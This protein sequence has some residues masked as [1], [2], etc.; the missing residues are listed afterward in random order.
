MVHCRYFVLSW[1]TPLFLCLVPFFSAR[2]VLGEKKL[3]FHPC[4]EVS[5][6]LPPLLYVAIKHPR[7]F[8]NGDP[9][10]HHHGFGYFMASCVRELSPLFQLFNQSVEG[11][12]RVVGPHHID[13]IL[14][15]VNLVNRPVSGEHILQHVECSHLSEYHQLV[16]QWGQE[17]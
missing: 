7:M 1:F 8:Q 13:C 14:L 3:V 17:D 2:N 4:L 10:G 9:F 6:L 11:F 5:G 16:H 15:E 12:H